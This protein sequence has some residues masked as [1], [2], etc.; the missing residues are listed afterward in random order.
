MTNF[1]TKKLRQN[2][3][4][5]QLRCVKFLKFFRFNDKNGNFKVVVASHFCRVLTSANTF[6]CNLSQGDDLCQ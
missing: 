4:I 1:I 3:C 5:L 6:I 2:R